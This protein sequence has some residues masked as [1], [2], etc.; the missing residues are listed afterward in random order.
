MI[1]K[2]IK[3]TKIVDGEPFCLTLSTEP[4]NPN[5]VKFDYNDGELDAI[6]FPKNM[7]DEIIKVLQDI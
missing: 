2:T 4:N 3:I 5:W 1:T 7:I 6:V